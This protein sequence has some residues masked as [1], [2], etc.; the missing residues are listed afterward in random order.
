MTDV[1]IVLW[2]CKRFTHHAVYGIFCSSVLQSLGTSEEYGHE[3]DF[4][5]KHGCVYD[6]Y[7]SGRRSHETEP[8]FAANQFYL[9]A[10]LVEH[11]TILKEQVGV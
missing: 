6:L 3:F 1:P 4:S 10:D 5:D 9:Y 8:V 2:H 7:F 11:E